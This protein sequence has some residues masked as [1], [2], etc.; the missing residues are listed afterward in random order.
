[1]APLVAAALSPVSAC[2][3]ARVE[4][5]RAA[6]PAAVPVPAARPARP[7]GPPE[8]IHLRLLGALRE[9][10]L[11][12]PRL[13]SALRELG[14]WPMQHADPLSRLPPSL[15]PLARKVTLA[16]AREKREYQLRE[17]LYA[18]PPFRATFRVNVPPGARLAFETASS[19]AIRYA[20]E[21]GSRRVASGLSRG[22]AVWAPAEIDLSA[23]AGQEVALSLV[24]EGSAGHLFF[25]APRLYGKADDAPPSVVLLAIDT[26]TAEVVGFSGGDRG[27][28][29]NMD[30]LAAEGV[31]FRQAFTNANWTRAS[32]LSMFASE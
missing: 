9:A 5:A 21:V 7:P 22:R 3:G 28:T 17:A 24:S 32:T 8:K 27:L 18:P 19:G 10:R 4:V 2:D 6:E 15:A 25:A 11:E 16:G 14:T 1:M 29:P 30:R 26:L 12:A 13:A 23:F 31:A 20:V